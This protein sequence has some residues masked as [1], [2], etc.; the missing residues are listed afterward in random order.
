LSTLAAFHTSCVA[1]D[2]PMRGEAVVVGN[3]DRR[4]GFERR[5]L[6][7]TFNTYECAA[8]GHRQMIERA[9][10]LVSF[11]KRR[12][13]HG[14]PLWAEAHWLDLATATDR[15]FHRNRC[16]IPAWLRTDPASWTVRVVFGH[17]QMRE[18]FAIWRDDLS[19]VAVEGAKLALIAADPRR[20][21]ARI[22][23]WGATDTTL[24]FVVAR[25]PTDVDRVEAPRSILE[26]PFPEGFPSHLLSDAW[27]NHRRF[28]VTPKPANPLDF[29]LYGAH[30][31]YAGGAVL[32]SIQP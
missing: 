32:R 31:L 13:I 23:Y 5:I 3:L 8:C 12:W 26:V 4:G 24:R 15:A 20:Y 11:E 18:R 1:C 14:Y 25:S 30:D 7:G 21:L 10:G 27:V 29:D 28:T 22:F 9:F 17:D 6:A 2:A 19:E 16:A